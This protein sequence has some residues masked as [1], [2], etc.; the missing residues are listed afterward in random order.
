MSRRPEFYFDEKTGYYRKRVKLQ[1]GTYKDIRAK[2]K[3]ELR[4]KLYEFETAKRLGV[5]FDD[6]T[7]VAELAVEWYQ[8]RSAGLSPSRQ[9]DYKSAINLRI[10]PILG[11][12]KVREVKPEYCQRVMAAS[13]QWSFSTQQ[14]TVST[15]KQ[16]FDCAVDNGLIVRSPAGKVKAGGKKPD[17]KKALTPEQCVQL[18]SATKGTRAYI[19][20]MLGLYAGL[21]REEIC[22]LRWNDIDLVTIPPRLT[23]ENAVRFDGNAAVFPSPLKSKAAHRTIPLPPNLAAALREEKTQSNSVFVV[24]DRDGKCVSLQAMKNI[25]AIIN[26]RAPRSDR[27]QAKRD[28]L[29]KELG[30]PLKEYHP[31]K[32]FQKIDFRPTPHLLRHTYITRLIESG[33][34]IKK[35]QYLAGHD[36]I[37]MTL[38]VYSHVVGN[39]PE[40]LIDA[41]SNAFSGQISGQSKEL[42]EKKI[43]HIND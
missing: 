12:M 13:A 11:T 20:I 4:G 19:F 6:N 39:S 36:D 29:E 10:C 1:D 9:E 34:D 43:F 22:G 37:R 30:R 31:P 26:R 7:T 32:D 38:G 5:S 27:Q 18:E 8:N 21:R 41:V 17:E 16:I 15:L 23:V 40:A 2:S 35:A 28:E 33:I 25:V 14:K 3:E 42:L 24:H